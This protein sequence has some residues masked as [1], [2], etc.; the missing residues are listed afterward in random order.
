MND[1][2]GKC[3]LVMIS[4]LTSPEF[5]WTRNQFLLNEAYWSDFRN[6]KEIY[7]SLSAFQLFWNECDYYKETCS[8]VY[9]LYRGPALFKKEKKSN[10]RKNEFVK[11]C[12]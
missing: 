11:V 10:K 2:E 9:Y 8:V 5:W 4:P 6:S 3:L 1:Q 12:M 7:F